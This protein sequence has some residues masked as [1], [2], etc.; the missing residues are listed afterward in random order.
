[1]RVKE[2][3]KN[4]RHIGV[5]VRDAEK[6]TKVLKNMFDLDDN[7]VVMMG[8][9]VTGGGSIYSF[10]PVAGSE[11]ELIEPIS[12]EFK[13]ML[14]DPPA[15]INHI[16]FTVTD[17]EQAVSLMNEKGVRLGHVTKSGILDTGRSKVAYFNP[18]DTGNILMEFVEPKK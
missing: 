13:A 18:E 6:S 4:V 16:A 8:T 10:I 5:I 2:L 12:E 7:E 3:I 15:G 17:I 11:F 1:M 14:G 9:D